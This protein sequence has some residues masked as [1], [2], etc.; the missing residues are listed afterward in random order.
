MANKDLYDILGVP[1]SASTDDIKKA[2]RKLAREYHPD[3]NK[4][5]DAEKK[6]KEI[7]EANSVLSDD[8]KRAQY[9]RFGTT[10][11]MGGPGGPGGP[12][13]FGGGFEGFDFSGAYGGDFN[14]GFSD[15]FESFFGGGFGRRGAGRPERQ[16]RRGDDLRYDVTITLEEAAF[17]KELELEIPHLISCPVCKGSGAKP[18]SKET[19]CKQCGGSGQVRHVQQTI[20]GSFTQI[21]TCPE[22]GGEGKIISETCSECRG[23]G[24]VKKTS[25]VKVDIP[26]GVEDGMKL[27]VSREGNAGLKGGQ[28]GDLY[29]YIR[30]REH[31]HFQREDD[32]IIA[33]E[34]IPFVTATLGGEVNVKTLD[35]TVK[36]KISAGTQPGTKL[37]LA[38]KGIQHLQASG[39]GDH[40][41]IINIDV[42]KVI[43]KKQKKLLEELAAAD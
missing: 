25:K 43:T 7:N 23:R 2:Y 9:D 1:R 22:C 36:L 40:Y 35:G 29:I 26:A 24:R 37:R 19:T 6:F 8:K 4:A 38:N 21:G 27:R 18:G 30:V 13:G 31:A 14:E 16:V 11:G 3:V 34:K 33:E 39:R 5:P 12:G 42:P 28:P 15:I 32:D 10:Q 17:G 20:L 41:V